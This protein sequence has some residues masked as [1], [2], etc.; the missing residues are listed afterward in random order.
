MLP[1]PLHILLILPPTS[2]GFL[3]GLLFDLEDEDD[4][5]KCST[6]SEL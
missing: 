5:L 3:L 6:L 4:V 2:V 1:L